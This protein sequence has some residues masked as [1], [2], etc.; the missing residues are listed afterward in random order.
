MKDVKGP[1]HIHTTGEIGAIMPITG[2]PKFDGK[3]K[4]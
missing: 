3:T 4:V 1:H 2:T